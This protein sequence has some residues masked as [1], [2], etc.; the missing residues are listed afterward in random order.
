MEEL[1]MFSLKRSA[2][3]PVVLLFGLVAGLIF[4][5]LATAQAQSNSG[6]V[7]CDSTLVTLLYIAEN[8][9]GFHSMYDVSK[10]DKGQ[11]TSLFDAMM[12]ANGSGGMTAE[13]TPEANM[14]QNTPEAS[15][16]STPESGMM[17]S[18]TMLEPGVVS[19]EDQLCTNLRA[20][21]DTF[22]YNT[23]TNAAMSG[24]SGQ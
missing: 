20:E 23:F 19:G 7:T 16:G 4:P 24:Q 5:A 12:A 13:A 18:T 2:L 1:A 15:M 6:Q 8:N 21:L 10:L 9:Y 22:F 11:Y 3:L 14:M 17:G